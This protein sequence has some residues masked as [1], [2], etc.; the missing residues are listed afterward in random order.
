MMMQ[1]YR[2]ASAMVVFW[3]VLSP[4][5]T[6]AQVTQWTE[7][8]RMNL[9]A[10]YAG[11][12]RDTLIQRYRDPVDGTLC[13]I[14]LPVTAQHSQPNGNGLVTYGPNTIGSIS[15]LIAPP[16]IQADLQPEN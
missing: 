9:E 11:P 14:Y 6:L 15:C 3:T 7:M 16:T 1:R 8:S 4:T 2:R 12:L 13:F 10:Q 5:M